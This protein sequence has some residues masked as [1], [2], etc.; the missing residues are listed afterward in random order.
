MIG[1]IGGVGWFLVATGV[2]VS[3]RLNG[4]L[5][6]D[7][8]TLSKL[9]QTDTIFLWLIPLILAV[10]KLVASI[11]VTSPF[12]TPAYFMA[13]PAIFYFFVAAIP[14]L[15]LDDLRQLGWMFPTPESGVPFYHF[16]TLYGRF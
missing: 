1:C 13:I 4:N 15:D 12:F 2:E 10:V 9:F 8:G 7:L 16:Y 14:E 3:A 6:Y 11:W 5:E